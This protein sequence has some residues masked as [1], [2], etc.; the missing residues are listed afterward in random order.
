VETAFP[1]LI[2]LV[3]L[4]EDGDPNDYIKTWLLSQRCA[5]DTQI[6]TSGQ[7]SAVKQE[8]PVWK[9]L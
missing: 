7:K 6:R 1:H 4:L 3:T 2:A 8:D 5:R 9:F